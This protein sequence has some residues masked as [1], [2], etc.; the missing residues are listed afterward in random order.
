MVGELKVFSRYRE[1]Y[2]GLKSFE[3]LKVSQ[4]ECTLLGCFTHHFDLY[5]SFYYLCNVVVE[6]Q[7][8]LHR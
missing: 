3:V 1:T 6:L 4:R 7:Y 5:A 2:K 8:R